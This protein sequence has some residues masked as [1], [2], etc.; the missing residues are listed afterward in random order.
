MGAC[1]ILDI[2]CHIYGSRTYLI[3]VVVMLCCCVE[4]LAR[5]VARYIGALSVVVRHIIELINYY[6]NLELRMTK[7]ILRAGLG[8]AAHTKALLHY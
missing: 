2:G 7:S 4:P 6:S 5:L 1:T 8:S 3:P